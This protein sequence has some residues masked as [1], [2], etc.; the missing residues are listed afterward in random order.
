[1]PTA[2]D[3]TETVWSQ[4]EPNF[5]VLGRKYVER[6]VFYGDDLDGKAAYRTFANGWRVQVYVGCQ[7]TLDGFEWCPDASWNVQHREYD[8]WVDV[9]SG[10]APSIRECA[11]AAEAAMH[12]T[13]TAQRAA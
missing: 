3:S 9:A 7:E 8:R 11:G 4:A 12:A 1:M 6:D 2:P 5:G 10:S 13:V